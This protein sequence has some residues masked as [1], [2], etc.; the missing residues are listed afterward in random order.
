MRSCVSLCERKNLIMKILA[1]IFA[2]ISEAWGLIFKIAIVIV[3]IVI[4]WS[5]I[6][7][8]PLMPR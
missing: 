7:V 6:A 3:A 2:L 5:F 1:L 8:V 4:A